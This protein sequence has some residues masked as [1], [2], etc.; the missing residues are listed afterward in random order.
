MKKLILLIALLAAFSATLFAGYDP[1]NGHGT[2]YETDY[3][4]RRYLSH[5]A[6]FKKGLL[7]ADYKAYNSDG[8]LEFAIRPRNGKWIIEI[9][10]YDGKQTAKVTMPAQSFYNID[11][12]REY[13]F[14]GSGYYH[15]DETS[16]EWDGP[17]APEDRQAWL[18]HTAYDSKNMPVSIYSEGLWDNCPKLRVHIDDYILN[19]YDS[20]QV[21]VWDNYGESQQDLLIEYSTN[22]EG[23]ITQYT[24]Y[25]DGNID[26]TLTRGTSTGTYQEYDDQGQPTYKLAITLPKKSGIT[27]PCEITGN[28]VG[29]YPSIRDGEKHFFTGQMPV[30]LTVRE[31]KI[32]S[33]DTSFPDIDVIVQPEK[34]S[35]L[36]ADKIEKYHDGKLQ[37]TM[38]RTF[39]NN[40]AYFN[41][42]DL[43]TWYTAKGSYN[44]QNNT[45]V[46][47]FEYKSTYWYT[48]KPATET[49]CTFAPTDASIDELEGLPHEFQT[50]DDL[51]LYGQVEGLKTKTHYETNG[52][53][54][55]STGTYHLSIPVGEHKSMCYAGDKEFM[56]ERRFYDENGKREG[57]WMTVEKD[58]IMYVHYQ[59][60][61]LEGRTVFFHDGQ[62]NYRTPNVINTD[63][64]QLT[65]V[66]E[67]LYHQGEVTGIQK[68]Y[69]PDY[70]T[71][72]QGKQ[73]GK[74]AGEL[75][76]IIDTENGNYKRLSHFATNY[77]DN[78][79]SKALHELHFDPQN[80]DLEGLSTFY[81]EQGQII[82][83]ENYHADRLEGDAVYR[84]VK[85]CKELRATFADG[86]WI[87]HEY[88]NDQNQRLVF[89]RID[90][91]HFALDTYSPDGKHLSHRKYET[92][93][94]AMNALNDGA[95]EFGWIDLLAGETSEPTSEY[96]LYD[97]EERVI[98]EGT[99]SNEVRH[100]D[101]TQKVSF[102]ISADRNEPI[103]YYVLGT[104]YLYSGK[105]KED[106]GNNLQ[107]EY[108]IKKGLRHGT[109]KIIDTTTKK[110]I[111]KIKYNEGK[112]KQ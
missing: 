54:T 101:Y 89:S 94:S 22:S 15:T 91:M 97:G 39:V 16:M 23:K 18:I 43:Q 9:Y 108:T 33:S 77:D 70:Y 87:K 52:D 13:V 98:E 31:K 86:K 32:N 56:T 79:Y 57:E 28:G 110:T 107:A 1:Y 30:K 34:T 4:G 3:A 74:H 76:I 111:Q 68:Y 88:E 45:L 109:A 69:Y 58:T 48:D 61:K 59:N 73:R 106:I 20:K 19:H 75:Y 38:E 93:A 82:Q 92:Y 42:H 7:T 78:T 67:T 6:T 72:D 51:T 21:S 71:D 11:D 112:A 84:N 80:G 85:F 64:T 81:N 95:Q 53:K 90:A 62:M 29:T 41:Y 36:M 44:I 104:E 47:E 50:F 60:D 25:R 37:S 17:V 5:E 83:Q 55:V 35:Y 8:S 10:N 24:K 27:I 26:F 102:I 105:F 66:Y 40:I 100:Y 49:T 65:L 96:T 2:I 14:Y 46:G 103:R 12:N 99:G 63:T